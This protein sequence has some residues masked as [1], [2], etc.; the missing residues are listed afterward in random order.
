MEKAKKWRERSE[1]LTSQETMLLVHNYRF[2]TEKVDQINKDIQLIREQEV[3][4][5]SEIAGFEA[6]LEELHNELAEADPEVQA[7]VKK[8]LS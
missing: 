8:L 6:R 3:V 2:F 4:S 7:L 1:E 5:H